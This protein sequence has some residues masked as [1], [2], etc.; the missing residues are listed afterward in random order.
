MDDLVNQ[1]DSRKRADNSAHAVDPQV[2]AGAEKSCPE[3]HFRPQAVAGSAVAAGE[4]FFGGVKPRP[5]RSPPSLFPAAYPAYEVLLAG[6]RGQSGSKST[7]SS[8]FPLFSNP[9]DHRVMS[10]GTMP[11]SGILGKNRVSSTFS[12]NILSSGSTTR[13]SRSFS[14]L[15]GNSWRRRLHRQNDALVFTRIDI[16]ICVRERGR[17]EGVSDFELRISYFPY[18]G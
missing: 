13:S 8:R 12:G 6:G 9:Y 10:I 7:F 11:P 15:S 5:C 1:P 16:P 18:G 3:I 2:A 17:G 4:I 14:R